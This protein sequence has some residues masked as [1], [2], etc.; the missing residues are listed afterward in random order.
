VGGRGIRM[1]PIPAEA[2]AAEWGGVRAPPVVLRG[3]GAGGASP[4]EALAK[5]TRAEG[6]AAAEAWACRWGG[7][8]EGDEGRGIHGG[9][10]LGVWVGRRWR[11]RR[12]P[13]DS[14]RRRR[15]RAGG[16][17]GGRGAG[18]IRGGGGAGGWAPRRG[19]S[20]LPP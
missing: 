11:R 3:G 13:R 16:I 9:G 15:G 10:G 19:Q 20:T 14:R 7:A 17:R 12:G 8:G 4:G 1:A 18:G 2:G 5:E 6:F